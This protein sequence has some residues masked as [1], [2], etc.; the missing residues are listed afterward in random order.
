MYKHITIYFFYT[1]TP[2]IHRTLELQQ[3]HS[4]T[5]KIP[6]LLMNSKFNS[7]KAAG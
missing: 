2:G 3:S 7:E 5:S 6:Q 1:E 4:Q